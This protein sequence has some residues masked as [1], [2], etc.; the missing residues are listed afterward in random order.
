MAATGVPSLRESRRADREA[1]RRAD[2]LDAAATVF[3]SKGYHAAQMTEIAAPPELSL[4]AFR[5]RFQN[6]DLEEEN[7][8]NRELLERINARN[9][10]MLT[11]TEISGRYYL[12]ICVLHL[13]T[14][15][16]VMEEGLAIILDALR[17]GRATADGECSGSQVRP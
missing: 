12:R 13:R 4:F 15:A 11:G 1:R 8:R 2:A 9:R 7:R 16:P 6:R 17:G 5:Q 10:I 14:H 3:S